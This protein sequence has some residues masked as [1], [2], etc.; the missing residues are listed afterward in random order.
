MTTLHHFV[1]ARLRLAAARAGS[2]RLTLVA[3]FALALLPRLY[4]LDAQSLWLD[5]GG[6]WVEVT[7]RSGKGWLALLA[8]LFS[9]DAGYPLYHLLLKA[10][11]ALAGDS[12][13]ALRFPSA[14]AG[15]AAVVAVYLAAAEV[16]RST[17]AGPRASAL[18][19][20]EGWPTR[21]RA[22]LP[23][24]FVALS[25]FALW[26]A[27][28]AKAYS[29]LLLVV[30]LELWALLRALR[31]E[32]ARA[33]L[34]VLALAL[35]SLF[36]HRLALLSASGVALAYA[37]TRGRL[38]AGDLP[39][40]GERRAWRS[41]LRPSTARWA[42]LVVAGA[43]GALGVAGTILA[44]RGEAAAAERAGVG[45]LVGL[46]LTF[47]RFSLDRWPGDVAG[48]LGL[49]APVWLLPFAALTLWGLAL[50]ARDASARGPAAIALLCLF[51]SPLA[52]FGLTLALAPVFQAR[53]AVS[54]FPAWALLLAYPILRQSGQRQEPE[55]GWGRSRLFVLSSVLYGAAVVAGVL[56][57]LQ[58]DRGL[59]SG[60]PVKEQW[61]EAV[62][63]LAA[64]AHP[65][66]LVIVHPYYVLPLYE[67]YA[68]RVTPD[69]LPQPVTF[70]IFGEGD[71][72]GLADPTRAQLLEHVRRRYEPFFNQV[73]RGKK[74][75]LLLIAPDHA[76]SVDPPKTLEELTAEWER[77]GA[78][79][80]RRP[81]AADRYGWLGLRF[82][83]PQRT[84]PCGGAEYVGVAVMCQ[85]FPEYFRLAG[86]PVAIPEPELPLA[87]VFGGE[88][89]LRGYTLA[90][91][92][93]AAR[94]GGTLPVTLFW[95]AAQPPTRAY[96]MFLHLCQ[97]CERP[98][99]AN[100]DGPPLFGYPPAGDTT[101]WRVGDPVHDE[102]AIRLPPDLP[103]GR[104][105]LLLGVYPADQPTIEARLAIETDARTLGA[106]RLVL[107]E[108]EIGP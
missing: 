55:A 101:T 21:A 79:P 29:L 46:G 87:A 91:H 45:P 10:W 80:A 12:E 86:D 97:D 14:L 93:G 38:A 78:D 84:W 2:M 71:R 102:R 98:P 60:A 39:R 52:L 69:P 57:L 53:Y 13:W 3:L 47:A 44:A 94:P 15:A 103:P 17:G 99:P 41:L 104:Y 106:N 64:R 35:A 27:Q 51:I 89:K 24:M 36:V 42:G 85:S 19:G 56:M 100:Q 23:A 34:L 48:F 37:L 22:L 11:V 70:P 88:L 30:A 67:Y 32:D 9:P 76:R 31:R 5:E 59:F 108:V 49:P 18:S 96:R 95:E 92:A 82:E 54:A 107:G 25:P 77:A 6:T 75:A 58:P 83:Y 68:P 62:A 28:D 105:T 61:R 40:P 16:A 20:A 1:S 8:E 81:V 90:L 74:R 72:G 50:L 43:C 7:G 66:D 65:D 26:H 63:E 33:W 73:A 4:R